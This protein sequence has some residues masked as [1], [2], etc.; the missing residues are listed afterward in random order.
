MKW[1]LQNFFDHSGGIGKEDNS[2]GCDAETPSAQE[3]DGLHTAGPQH[4]ALL[5]LHSEHHPGESHLSEY[6]QPSI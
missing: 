4:P 6:T 5:H 1:I 2:T 3:H